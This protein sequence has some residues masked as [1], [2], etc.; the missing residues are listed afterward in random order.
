MCYRF[1]SF[2]N[3]NAL[4]HTV[5][6]TYVIHLKGNGRY[7]NVEEQLKQ[8]PLTKHVHILINKGYKNCDK[9]GINAPALDLIDAFK[10]CMN[11]AKQYNNILILEDDFIIHK[12]IHQHVNN[13]NNFVEENTDFIY[14]LGCIPFIMIPYDINNYRGISAGTH[15]VIYSKSVRDKILDNEKIKDW[16]TFLNLHLLNYIYYTPIIYQLIPETENSKRWGEDNI[17]LKILGI[18]KFKMYSFLNLDKQVE[19]GYSIFYLFAKLWYILILLFI[20][21]IL[22]IFYITKYFKKLYYKYVN[23]KRFKKIR[24]SC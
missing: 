20:F 9:P 7:E 23:E 5:D 14:R 24:N 11:H 15:A 2:Q 21:Y 3:E 10:F 13:I 4:F 12:D 8:Y 22:R 17:F 16:D 6:A 19:P 1:K 18:I